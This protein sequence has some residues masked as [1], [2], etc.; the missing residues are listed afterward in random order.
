MFDDR[1]FIKLFGA[2]FTIASIVLSFFLLFQVNPSKL[3]TYIT[4]SFAVIGVFLIAIK[5]FSFKRGDTEI[6]V[7]TENDEDTK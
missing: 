3:L 5:S 2:I 6:K 7:D 4:I 1:S